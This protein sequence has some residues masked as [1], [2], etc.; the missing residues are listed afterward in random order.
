MTSGNL[1]EAEGGGRRPFTFDRVV[2]LV[3]GCALCVFILWLVN[4]LSSVLLPFLVA[5][6]VAYM[7]EPLV[8]Q[9]RRLMRVKRRFLPVMVTLIEVMLIMVLLGVFF[10][11]SIISEMH[12]VGELVRQYASNGATV[13]FIPETVHTYLREHID[14]NLI[15][16]RLTSEDLQSMFNAATGVISSGFD[17][18]MAIFDWFLVLLY[19]LFIMLD[20]ERLLAGF[21]SMVPPRYRDITFSIGND[22]KDSMNHYFRGQA[23]VALLVGILFAIG[24]VIVG[25]PL[26]VVLGLFIGV[27]NMVPY[28]QLI[29]IPITTLLCLVYSV[30][31]GVDFWPVWWQCMIVYCVVQCIQDLVLTPRI[32][33]KVMGLNPAIILLSLSVWGS[34]LG[35]V[36]LIIALPLTTLVLAYYNRYIIE[37]ESPG[38][39]KAIEE[40]ETDDLN[41]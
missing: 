22:V 32:M 30:Q 14:F 20:Y 16:S 4:R 26:A 11:P 21:K 13:A 10:V 15:Y 25:I 28:L 12:Q 9:N 23:L 39:A 7:L 1:K 27:L 35:F 8:L 3:L 33:G 34:L 31:S 36:G 5:W 40:A 2:R 38:K 24:F 37:H 17:I 41:T 6:L 19:I 29:S 18:V